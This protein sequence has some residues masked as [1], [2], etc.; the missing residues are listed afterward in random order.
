MRSIV[1]SLAYYCMMLAITVT[2]AYPIDGHQKRGENQARPTKHLY[3]EDTATVPQTTDPPG[4]IP[5]ATS[6]VASL[7]EDGWDA[8][9][10]ASESE[11][12]RAL[13]YIYLASFG[14]TLLCISLRRQDSLLC[15]RSCHIRNRSW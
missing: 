6:L 3:T 1:L 13:S 5:E 15:L 10:D 4:F 7:A 14:L 2:V 8:L 12:A 11:P 9:L